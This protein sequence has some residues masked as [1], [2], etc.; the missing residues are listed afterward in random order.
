MLEQGLRGRCGLRL[1]AVG[2]NERQVLPVKGIHG[3]GIARRDQGR[4]HRN[5]IMT[6]QWECEFRAGNSS[7]V[8]GVAAREVFGPR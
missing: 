4:G 8:S 5:W 7:A 3:H 1:E 2:V 6:R